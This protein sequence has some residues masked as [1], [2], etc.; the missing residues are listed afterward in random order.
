M[1]VFQMNS[2]FKNTITN[3]TENIRNL[4]D[5]ISYRDKLVPFV[6]AGMSVSMGYKTWYNFLNSQLD[7]LAKE[8]AFKEKVE[9]VRKMLLNKEYL[10]VA[11]EINKMYN[12]NLY[13]II[14]REFAPKDK[15]GTA[16]YI[17]WLRQIGNKTILTTNY[18]TM[19]ET[20]MRID[21]IKYETI[22]PYSSSN[23]IDK[24]KKSTP[25]I[26]KLH[27]SYDDRDS[28]V[29]TKKQFEEKYKNNENIKKTLRYYWISRTLLFMGCSLE[30]DYL[31]EYMLELAGKEDM[32]HYAL[33]EEPHNKDDK[34]KKQI[35]LLRLNIKPI[36]YKNNKHTLILEI[37]DLIKEK[38]QI[39]YNPKYDS[40]QSKQQLAEI[41]DICKPFIDSVAIA[42]K[43]DQRNELF[44]Y[45]CQDKDKYL[46]ISSIMNHIIESSGVN[47]LRILG[48]SGTG[49]STL[50]SL[51]YLEFKD[52]INVFTQYIPVYID[53]HYYE[54]KLLKEAITDLGA[55]ISDL[56]NLISKQQNKILLFIDGLDE[57]Q[58]NNKK[59]EKC[60]FVFTDNSDFIG[61]TVYSIGI[62]SKSFKSIKNTKLNITK[63]FEQ[64]IQLNLIN[65]DD[66]IFHKITKHLLRIYEKP[67][68]KKDG[69]NIVHRI[70]NLTKMAS[71]NLTDFRTINLLISQY[72]LNDKI[73]EQSIGEIYSRYYSSRGSSNLNNLAEQVTK[74]IIDK[75]VSNK[76]NVI[77]H[78]YK[79]Q[80]NRNFLFAHH[81]VETIVN[82]KTDN[83]KYFNS[84]FSP[85]INRFIISI[86]NNDNHM[87]TNF[88]TSAIDIYEV[89]D[90]KHQIQILYLLGRV[91]YEKEKAVEFLLGEYKKSSSEK[92]KDFVNDHN[93]L[94]KYRTTGI[95][96][97][98]TECNDMANDFYYNLIYHDRLKELN[99]LFHLDYYTNDSYIIGEERNFDNEILYTEKNMKTLYNSLYHTIANKPKNGEDSYLLSIL[100]IIDLVTYDRYY[101][102]NSAGLASNKS[103]FLNLLNKIVEKKDIDNNIIKNYLIYIS[104]KWKEDILNFKNIAPIEDNNVY[105]SLILLLYELK[106]VNRK[107][108]SK[109]GR[110]IEKQG[111]APESVADHTWA[112]GLLAMTLLSDDIN[113][114][115]FMQDVSNDEYEEYNKLHI[116]ELLSVHDLAES[117]TG[118]II[119]K[120][121][122]DSDLEKEFIDKLKFYDSYPMF[123]S[124]RH[125]SGLM[126]EYSACKSINAR[127]ASDI[128]KLEPLIQLFIYKDKL[129]KPYAEVRSEWEKSVDKRIVTTLGIKIYKFI[130][131]K[132]TS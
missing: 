50:I 61:K 68:K 73:L 18:D 15:V 118:D 90:K 113:Q 117:Y 31:I 30:K 131:D 2:D 120:H 63:K 59:L 42:C 4:N 29:F 80:T 56:K 71:G 22:I 5:L 77:I 9:F 35:A 58:R 40:K 81:Y 115:P 52:K 69:S 103:G 51:L 67:Q 13:E 101:M 6:G 64:T 28:I 32:H 14:K 82:K 1:G 23:I 34:E 60:L 83:Y 55:K 123:G 3:D 114:C 36:W 11:D 109:E 70:R 108:W 128:D 125:I 25:L 124:F 126:E 44:K 92:D 93:Y 27:G 100:T 119:N 107:G 7:F 45:I 127:I 49:K 78:V 65:T 74:Y 111:I 99:R 17:R 89:L 97:I 110:Q 102:N 104:T 85:S 26:I 75:N 86:I 37:L 130:S 121:E 106:N 88:V 112:C 12:N 38:K 84:I 53:L 122:K 24:D 105:K 98:Y 116:I 54:E 21:K 72:K 46:N 57:Y 43:P 91:K 16:K 96:L 79:S 20:H 76:S 129:E 19:L 132:I 10:E 95:S 62:N 87:C 41:E 47:T 66:P 8:N 39:D 48:E 94:M 33:L